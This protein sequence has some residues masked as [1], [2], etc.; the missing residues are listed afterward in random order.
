MRATA[1]RHTITICCPEFGDCCR[2]EQSS[3]RTL[4]NKV[5]RRAMT[6]DCGS[7][8]N[9]LKSARA[10]GVRPRALPRELVSI[11][12]NTSARFADAAIK[13]P[14]PIDVTA[15]TARSRRVQCST[16]AKI[17]SGTSGGWFTDPAPCGVGR[18][19]ERRE[20]GRGGGR[21]CCWLASARHVCLPHPRPGRGRVNGQATAGARGGVRDG[22]LL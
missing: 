7:I 12:E 9:A 3:M 2:H 5:S 19:L 20:S 16:R 15:K 13:A 4:S 17:T 18:P 6:S 11:S 21:R 8:P 22:L 14:E 1:C 10:S